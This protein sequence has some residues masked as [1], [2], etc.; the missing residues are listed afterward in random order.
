MSRADDLRIRDYLGHILEAIER[1]NRYVVNVDEVEFYG[2][3]KTQDAIIRN[4]EIIGE[5]CH[6]VE[7]YHPDFAAKHPA[8]PWVVAYEMRN[9]L[10]HGYF[11]VDMEVVW[12]TIQTDLPGMVNQ[13]NRL[14]KSENMST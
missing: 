7:R 3:E 12:R 5:A 13:I 14:L 9:T 6:N 10:A 11:L 8:V 4:F 2:D 1:I